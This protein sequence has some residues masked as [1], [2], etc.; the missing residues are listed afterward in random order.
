MTTKPIVSAIVPARNEEENIARAVESLA[1][2]PEIAEILV[3]NDQSTDRTGSILL[4]LRSQVPALR[5]IENF[6]PPP[7]GWTGKNW[8][9]SL[10]AAQAKEEWLLFTDADVVHLPGATAHALEG[11]KR[12]RAALVSY[13]PEQDMRTWWERA[14]IPFIYCRLAVHYS[15]ARINDPLLPDAAANGQFLMI[16]RGVY[17]VVGGHTAVAGELVEDVALA[18]RVKKAGQPIYFASGQGIARTR[19][20][21]SFSAMWEGWKK[22]LYLLMG[23]S[24]TAAARELALVLPWIP[25]AML[26]LG[27]VHRLLPL[28]GLVLLLGRHAGYALELRRNR[29]PLSVILYYLAGVFFYA[30]ALIA[31]AW[32]CQRGRV[33]WKGREYSIGAR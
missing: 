28:V 1:T 29:F 11:A 20:Y 26:C 6:A 4:S 14:V 22:N 31:S 2:Q 5:V 18:Q 24:P 16:R 3:V 21:S 23:R 13:S 15:Y 27:G 8:A 25:L 32:S 10:G 7:E 12:N 17:N 9:A 33:L 19:M 30:T